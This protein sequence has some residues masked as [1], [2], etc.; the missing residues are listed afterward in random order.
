MQSACTILYCHLWPIWLYTF[1]HYLTNGTIFRKKLL[2]VKYVFWF[3]LQLL[4]EIFLI[5][6]IIQQD[7]IINVHESS[8]EV[9]VT[10]Q[11]LMILDFDRFIKNTQI[12]NFIKIR[13]VGAKLFHVDRQ[14]D[15]HDEASI[16]FHKFA[17]APKTFSNHSSSYV[18][19]FSQQNASSS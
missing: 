13:P 4:S 6:R 12:L 7:I 9:P 19:P 1:P 11:I 16:R 3:L 18:L 17:N 2:N 5:L 8:C 15:R 10:H 14:T